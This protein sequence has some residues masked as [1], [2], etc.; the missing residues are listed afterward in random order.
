MAIPP[1]MSWARFVFYST[2]G[3]VRLKLSP[4]PLETWTF[5]LYG[6]TFGTPIWPSNVRSSSMCQCHAGKRFA[7]L[8]SGRRR[9]RL[10]DRD[11]RH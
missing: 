4:Q 10:H 11:I 2:F 1:R 9:E 6:Q 5:R 3:R 8:L 7:E